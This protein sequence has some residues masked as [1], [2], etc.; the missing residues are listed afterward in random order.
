[1]HKN[2]PFSWL[3]EKQ[4]EKMPIW[5]NKQRSGT[6]CVF[7]LLFHENIN[8]ISNTRKAALSPNWHEP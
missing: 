5:N 1:M 4:N 2:P 8:T 6:N 3:V 7:I